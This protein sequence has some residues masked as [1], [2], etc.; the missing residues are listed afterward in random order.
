VA[1]RAA[2]ISPDQFHSAGVPL[3]HIE[4]AHAPDAAV[5]NL[6]LSRAYSRCS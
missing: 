1:Q 3:D 5:R 6:L 4:V 2:D